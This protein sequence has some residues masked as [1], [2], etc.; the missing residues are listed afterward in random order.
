M[1]KV[2]FLQVIDFETREPYDGYIDEKSV[3]VICEPKGIAYAEGCTQLQLVD[4]SFR[5]VLG[6]LYQVA[7]YLWGEK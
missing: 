5:L 6:N 4:G 2:T 7:G 3:M 1:K